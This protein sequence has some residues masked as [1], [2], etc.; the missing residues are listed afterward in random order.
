MTT[1]N[2]TNN[3][4]ISTSIN[5]SINKTNNTNNAN[6]TN[7]N[8]RGIQRITN[9]PSQRGLCA[10]DWGCWSLCTVT[11]AHS[12][13]ASLGLDFELQRQY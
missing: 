11:V 8:T 12:G 2:N 10:G 6:N 13:R 5:I 1:T 3:S 9:R 4:S 7:T